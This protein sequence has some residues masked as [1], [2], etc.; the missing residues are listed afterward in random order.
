MY[1]F[2]ASE[3]PKRQRCRTVPPPV[4]TMNAFNVFLGQ[5][6]A[7]IVA[8]GAVLLYLKSRSKKTAEPE[9]PPEQ[10]PEVATPYW[11]GNWS[12]IGGKYKE[13]KIARYRAVY[14]FIYYPKGKYTRLSSIDASNRQ[15]IISFKEGDYYQ[16]VQLVSDFIKGHFWKSQMK[17]WTL[18][19]IPASTAEKTERRFKTFCEEVSTETGI[20]NGYGLVRRDADRID[21]RKEKKADT[22]EGLTFATEGI[23]GRNILLFDDITTRGLSFL[24]IADNLVSAGA[25]HVIGFFLG[26]SAD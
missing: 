13:I 24:Q 22:L 18:C 6:L 15:S 2:G 21:S 16:A 7:L 9:Q 23:I 25:N 10:E 11:E 12:Y 17:K 14:C 20:T 3:D 5:F 1:I 19:V 26:K 4:D 8:A